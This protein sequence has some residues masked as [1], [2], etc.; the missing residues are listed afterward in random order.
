M[1]NFRNKLWQE[2]Y[3]RKWHAQAASEIFVSVIDN[4]N[5]P[6]NNLAL[7]EYYEN[8]S[9]MRSMFLIQELFRNLGLRASE[10]IFTAEAGLQDSEDEYKESLE[11]FWNLY[12]TTPSQ[13]APPLLT[14]IMYLI[15]REGRRNIPV[16]DEAE[17]I[18]VKFGQPQNLPADMQDMT[19]LRHDLSHEPGGNHFFQTNFLI[20]YL[21]YNKFCFPS[22]PP[23][24]L[25]GETFYWDHIDAWFSPEQLEGT[26][27]SKTWAGD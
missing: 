21:I 5:A 25:S 9:H 14:Q 11:D 3:T 19:R 18:H 22:S 23:D 1:A 15:M 12:M 20:G 7:Q 17:R 26:Y 2:G 27:G 24:N 13:L 8:Y 10:N 6:E 16:T 4:V